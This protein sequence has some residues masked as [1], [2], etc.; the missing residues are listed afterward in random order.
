MYSWASHPRETR[1][2]C[3]EKWSSSSLPFVTAQKFNSGAQLPHSR[4]IRLMP[5]MWPLTPD[6]RRGH[7]PC[8][9][10]AWRLSKALLLQ[11]QFAHYPFARF[12]FSLVAC[13]ALICPPVTRTN[14]DGS[15]PWGGGLSSLLPEASGKMDEQLTCKINTRLP[16]SDKD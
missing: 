7:T 3:F 5:T 12:I 4:K 16:G 9:Q 1:A 8:N 14:A 10:K 13:S 11:P 2:L 6:P 15:T